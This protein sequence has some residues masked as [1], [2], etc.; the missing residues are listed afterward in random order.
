MV[1]QAAEDFLVSGSNPGAAKY[2]GSAA[3]GVHRPEF[4][5]PT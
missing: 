5:P 3:A 1:M 2:G 4:G